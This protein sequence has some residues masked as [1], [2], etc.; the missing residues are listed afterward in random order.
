MMCLSTG[1]VSAYFCRPTVVN[2]QK[3]LEAKLWHTNKK[4]K[5]Q[6]RKYSISVSNLVT[7]KIYLT[8]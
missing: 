7:I 6:T 4:K 2:A 3:K 1:I 5:I 8:T